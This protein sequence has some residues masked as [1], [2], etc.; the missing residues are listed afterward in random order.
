MNNTAQK[1]KNIEISQICNFAN[2]LIDNPE[3]HY[4]LLRKLFKFV[5]TNF[6]GIVDPENLATITVHS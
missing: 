1:G 6:T 5:F 2:F 3:L 4:V